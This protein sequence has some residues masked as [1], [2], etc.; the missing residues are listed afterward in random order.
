MG[1]SWWE[2]LFTND[3]FKVRSA[4]PQQSVGY[5]HCPRLK[6]GLPGLLFFCPQPEECEHW[7]KPVGEKCSQLSPG[8]SHPAVAGVSIE[9]SICQASEHGR[10]VC[11]MNMS[12]G[13]SIAGSRGEGPLIDSEEVQQ[14][15]GEAVW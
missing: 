10:H 15:P 5:P 9:A 2:W 4:D 8:E 13:A 12:L 14:S 7:K 6:A 1:Q 11:W 3:E